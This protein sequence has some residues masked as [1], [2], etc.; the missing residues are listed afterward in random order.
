MR[1]GLRN[2]TFDAGIAKQIEEGVL[3][4]RA[5]RWKEAEPI[6]A[7]AFLELGQKNTAWLNTQEVKQAWVAVESRYRDESD[8]ETLEQ[9]LRAWVTCFSNKPK[10]SGGAKTPGGAKPPPPIEPVKKKRK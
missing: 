9:A 3:L 1:L 4:A 2:H 8:P 7:A 10:T 5:G 6:L